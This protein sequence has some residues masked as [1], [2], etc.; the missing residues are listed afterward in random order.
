MR[1]KHWQLAAVAAGM[2]ILV[3]AELPARVNETPGR[4]PAADPT[5]VATLQHDPQFILEAVAR[6]MGIT[7]RPEFPPP[8]IRLESRTPLP[9]LQAAAERQWGFRPHVF[10][11]TYASA[12]NEIF[13]IDD[14]ALYAQYGGTPDDSL[15]HELV[16]YLQSRYRRDDFRTDWSE[17]EAVA[18]QTWFRREYM[19]PRL[20]AAAARGP[21]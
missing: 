5:A 12:G 15:A 18:I 10:T 6:R 21:R 2:L 4:T 11:T 19:E 3:A 14:P 8:A 13:L 17:T 16:H 1:P 7:L 9:R 20:A